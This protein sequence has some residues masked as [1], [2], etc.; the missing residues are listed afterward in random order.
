[1]GEQKK[2]QNNPTERSGQNKGDQATDPAQRREGQ[3][4]TQREQGEDNSQVTTETQSDRSD[5]NEP[6]GN[7]EGQPERV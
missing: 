1:M 7:V 5:R 6:E 4:G 3:S 2:K